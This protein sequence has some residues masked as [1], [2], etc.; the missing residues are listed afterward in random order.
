MS[1]FIPIY[2]EFP[3]LDEAKEICSYICDQSANEFFD[4][5]RIPIMTGNISIVLRTKY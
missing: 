5:R 4:K 3:S 2:F 1:L